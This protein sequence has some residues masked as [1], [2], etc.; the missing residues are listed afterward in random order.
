MSQCLEKM[1]V[2]A[3]CVCDCVFKFSK[4]VIILTIE[5]AYCHYWNVI[6]DCEGIQCITTSG[7]V[8]CLDLGPL[9]LAFACQ[10]S[11]LLIIRARF[12]CFK[13]HLTLVLW[14]KFFPYLVLLH[15]TH[16]FAFKRGFHFC[17][18][19]SCKLN[20]GYCEHTD[21]THVKLERVAYIIYKKYIPNIH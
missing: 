16:C 6:T 20:W 5:A 10:H 1:A 3:N 15:G 14:L 11:L 7:P 4:C 17:K 21:W 19:C 2:D 9:I 18:E 12:I 8:F 13:I